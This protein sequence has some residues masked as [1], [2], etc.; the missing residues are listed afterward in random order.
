MADGEGLA[1]SHRAGRLIRPGFALDHAAMVDAA[2]A[3]HDTT[4]D[5]RYLTDARRWS[6]HLWRH[7]RDPASGLTG[8]TRLETGELPVIPRP[9]HD[10]AV[11]NALGLQAANLVRIARKTG[12]NDDRDRAGES[13]RAALAAAA[14]APM[15]H[16]SVLNAYDL[17]RNGVEIVL[18][19]P[20]REALHAAARRLPHTL[21]T[22]VDCPA[23]D[24]LPADHPAA[25]MLAQAGEGAAF[26]CVEGRCLPPVTDPNRLA[27][28]IAAER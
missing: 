11:P 17:A 22:L 9:S 23:A 14:R 20:K 10:D 15:A 21:V 6:A 19:G 5:P 13:M 26:I 18:A 25:A 16:A 24:A 28:A 7:Y 8:M 4:F 3:L 2:L 1:Q 12:R 27:E